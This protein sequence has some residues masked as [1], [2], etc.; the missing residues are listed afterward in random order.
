MEIIKGPKA[1][2]LL[3]KVVARV[4]LTSIFLLK[5]SLWRSMDALDFERVGL[6]INTSGRLFEERDDCILAKA[7]FSLSGAPVVEGEARER[8]EVTSIKA[9]YILMYALTDNIKLTKEELKNFCDINPV[10]NAWPYWREFVHSSV[11][12]MG[13]PTITMP[14]LKFRPTKKEATKEQREAKALEPC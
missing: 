4:D 10:Y 3:S 6:E 13:L 1:F 11:D 14:L 12:R 7:T 5:S 8:K 9:E 2:K